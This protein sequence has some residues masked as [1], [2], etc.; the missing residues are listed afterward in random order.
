MDVRGGH[1]LDNI[2]VLGV[3]PEASDA[4]SMLIIVR[5]VQRKEWTTNGH[6]EPLQTKFATI[7]LV[8][9]IQPSQSAIRGEVTEEY[10]LGFHETQSSPLLMLE[11]R[12][13]TLSLR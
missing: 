9:S 8:E 13:E 7:M 4:D 1:I 3:L 12:I 2:V 11:L 10:S 6:T 5:F